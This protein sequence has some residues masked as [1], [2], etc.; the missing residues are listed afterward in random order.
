MQLAP[1]ASIIDTSDRVKNITC[2]KN[3]MSYVCEICGKGTIVGRS[4][5]HGRGVAGRRWK[6][7]AQA[8]R[9][10]FKPNLQK[11]TFILSSGDKKQMRVCTKCLK[12]AKKFGKVKDFKNIGVV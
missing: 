12:A 6:K 10:V 4:Q 11:K 9:R 7:R 5:Q 3:N 8:T 1:Y 2:F